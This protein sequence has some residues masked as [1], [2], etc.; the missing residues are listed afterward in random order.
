MIRRPPR[1]TLFP[2][3]TLFRSG[4]RHVELAQAVDDL[5]GRDLVRAVVAVAARVVHRGRLQQA[6]VVVAAEGAPTQVGQP[7]ELTDRQHAA[8]VHPPPPGGSNAR[9]SPSERQPGP[10]MTSPT[11]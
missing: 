9:P 4:Q 8:T 11:G 5:G 2:Y 6:R 1:S 3:T 7:G 10:G